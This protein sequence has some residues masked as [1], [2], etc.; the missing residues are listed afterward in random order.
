M[1]RSL[2][3]IAADV[4]KLLSGDDDKAVIVERLEAVQR[5]YQG[6]RDIGKAKQLRADIAAERER[7]V[8]LKDKW[9][10]IAA[11]GIVCDR[12]DYELATLAK[13]SGPDP[14]YP[15]FDDVCAILARS[16]I[17]QSPNKRLGK[18][19]RKLAGYL[20]E[21]AT[22]APGHPLERVC[23]RATSKK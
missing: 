21:A 2:D 14:H 9:R 10:Y 23:R 3:Q 4:A 19:H 20:Y 5:A 13:V 18:R 11:V 17:L 7:L 6:T 1:P 16:M 15:V 22:G 8:Q 12:T